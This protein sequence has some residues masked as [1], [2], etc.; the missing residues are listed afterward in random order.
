APPVNYQR[1]YLASAVGSQMVFETERTLTRFRK[2][3]GTPSGARPST[4]CIVELV[5]ISEDEG[6]T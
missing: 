5:D 2:C 3:S 1:D 4:T 6:E